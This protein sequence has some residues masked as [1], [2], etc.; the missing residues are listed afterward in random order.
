MN[1]PTYNCN[2]FKVNVIAIIICGKW[3][4]TLS[5]R[6][7]VFAMNANSR[8]I[9]STLLLRKW[10]KRRRSASTN[11]MYKCTSRG[12]NRSFTNEIPQSAV[13]WRTKTNCS[14]IYFL[15]LLHFRELPSTNPNKKHTQPAVCLSVYLLSLQ[16][17]VS[18]CITR[19]L[20]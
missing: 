2:Q 18:E 10:L 14:P 5:L 9:T 1:I 3:Q 11:E 8:Y 16:T 4:W 15:S 20:W 6:R 19:A 12:I 17:R 13:I 7:F